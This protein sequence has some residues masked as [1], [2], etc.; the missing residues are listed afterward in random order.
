MTNTEQEFWLL[1][2]LITME[3]R[4][5]AMQCETLI[6]DASGRVNDETLGRLVAL[7]VGSGTAIEFHDKL[8]KLVAEL[9]QERGLRPATYK[10]EDVYKCKMQGPDLHGFTR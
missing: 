5:V 8:P 9:A 4:V 1:S 10:S 7:V 6:W 2:E 3:N